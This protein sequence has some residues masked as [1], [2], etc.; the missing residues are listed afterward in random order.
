MN[1]N[2]PD[3]TGGAVG[4]LT[5]EELAEIRDTLAGPDGATDAY[6]TARTLMA[7]LDAERADRRASDKRAV[8]RPAR[9][10][11]AEAI[12]IAN[13]IVIEHV[14][15]YPTMD[16]PPGSMRLRDAIVVAIETERL[17]YAFLQAELD[18]ANQ[19]VIAFSER[20]LDLNDRALE[21]T[22][23]LLDAQPPAAAP[24]FS[25]RREVMAFAVLMEEKAPRKRSQGWLAPCGSDLSAPPPPRGDRGAHL[26]QQRPHARR[27]LAP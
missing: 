26:L 17:Y 5:D 12:G 1:Q 24:A 2:T 18:A 25:A 11:A 4:R 14:T 7:E 8:S 9:R 10:V 23:K 15:G 22:Q 20:I 27:L 21:L 3:N 13:N 19:R 16:P 6:L